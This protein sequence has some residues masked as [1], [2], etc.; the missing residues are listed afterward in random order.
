MKYHKISFFTKYNLSPN[1][2]LEKLRIMFQTDPAKRKDLP[3]VISII[4]NQAKLFLEQ[5]LTPVND[6]VKNSIEEIHTDLLNSFY[7]TESLISDNLETFFKNYYLFNDRKEECSKMFYAKDLSVD[8]VKVIV[9]KFLDS[10]LNELTKTIANQLEKVNSKSLQIIIKGLEG[11]EF[12]KKF[13]EMIS[14]KLESVFSKIEDKE[15]LKESLE[16]ISSLPKSFLENENI[17]KSY[18]YFIQKTFLKNDDFML[19]NEHYI[20]IF[21]NLNQNEANAESKVLMDI[22]YKIINLREFNK[23]NF[24]TVKKQTEILANNYLH[25]WNYIKT[26]KK[27]FDIEQFE[28]RLN[29]LAI[30]SSQSATWY[31][32]YYDLLKKIKNNSSSYVAIYDFIELIINAGFPKETYKVFSNIL[33]DITG[34]ESDISKWA[35][36]ESLTQKAIELIKKEKMLISYSA[37][38]S[39]PNIKNMI[40]SPEYVDMIL[41]KYY[42][43]HYLDPELFPQTA[44]NNIQFSAF[45]LLNFV[46]DNN[47]RMHQNS[48]VGNLTYKGLYVRDVM[49]TMPGDW[50]F[51]KQTV[52]SFLRDSF[53]YGVYSTYGTS[54]F[55]NYKSKYDTLFKNSSKHIKTPALIERVNIGKET[56]ERYNNALNLYK[57]KRFFQ[58]MQIFKELDDYEKSRYYYEKSAFYINEGKYNEANKL[59]EDKKYYESYNIYLELSDFKDAKEKTT[60]S[61]ELYKK[62][63]ISIAKE[64]IDK[65][66]YIE[67]INILKPIEKDSLEAKKLIETC[68]SL[69]IELEY[70]KA[71]T[72]FEEGKFEQSKSIFYSLNKYKKS[73][74][75]IKEIDYNLEQ[76]KNQKEYSLAN[77]LVEEFK[78]VEDIKKAI[79][80]YEKLSVKKYKNSEQLLFE[81]KEILAKYLLNE[82]LKKRKR[83]I[84]RATIAVATV[85]VLILTI[86][87]GVNGYRTKIY[88]DLT[89]LVAETNGNN[90]FEEIEQL[91]KKLPK[92]YKNYSDLEEEYNFKRLNYLVTNYK[93]N[94]TDEIETLFKKLN[95]SNRNINNIRTSYNQTLDNKYLA[96]YNKLLN[97]IKN[98]NGTQSH[99]T[100]ITQYINKIPYTYKN[101]DLIASQF[102][103]I[104]EIINN[105]NVYYDYN[106][107]SETKSSSI[108]SNLNRLVNIENSSDWNFKGFYSTLD[109]R[110]V[111]FGGHWDT[112]DY[113]FRWYGDSSGKTI[114][115]S[116][117]ID[118]NPNKS[119]Y[120]DTSFSSSGFLFYIYNKND[121]ND[122]IN[123]I[124]FIEITKIDSKLAIRAY[125]YK[126]QEY[127]TMYLSY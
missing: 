88:N 51:G 8:E 103:N 68:N 101:V 10:L 113:S 91:F 126:T 121:K 66:L 110:K 87:L 123:M 24:T 77:K 39:I 6:S 55:S 43:L 117:P 21:K 59:F 98:Y 115:Y 28:K 70:T 102:D 76:I 17:Y 35:D 52:D 13:E 81:T 82:K 122:K 99:N 22:A 109:V 32:N 75:Y 34:F 97:A 23:L 83:I 37:L 63:L 104:K 85:F 61:Y 48:G 40:N 4:N 95:Y 15:Y 14:S 47:Y 84:I 12:A 54:K 20:S 9:Q 11:T 118:K 124:R 38:M 90:N 3:I 114:S 18:L 73:E 116:I 65:L 112:E 46:D 49:K 36:R 111:M 96:D 56:K 120:F 19:I 119:Y 72:L 125:I 60:L 107:M 27:I 80:L 100:Q 79:S 105:V 57:N 78:T 33:L 25:Y 45:G 41:S 127:V 50:K 5:L 7:E 58:A 69:Q 86:S 62:N 42:F 30:I 29:I 74:E 44:I 26:N 93:I 92:N 64:K 31:S 94:Y 67:A 106:N 16:L 2:S 53:G 89:K 71:I 108:R 1:I